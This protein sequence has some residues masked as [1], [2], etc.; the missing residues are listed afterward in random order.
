MTAVAS[1]AVIT[2]VAVVL[3]A[4]TSDPCDAAP[5][6]AP[7]DAITVAAMLAIAKRRGSKNLVFAAIVVYT[8]AADVPA[9]AAAVTA[10]AVTVADDDAVTVAKVTVAADASA[11]ATGASTLTSGASVSVVVRSIVSGTAAAV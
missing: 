11:L 1:A 4:S 9:V 8:T 5:H 7:I 3:A 2:I 10:V 6:V